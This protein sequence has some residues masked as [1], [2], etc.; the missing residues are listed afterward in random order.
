MPQPVAGAV[1]LGF[2][3]TLIGIG[4]NTWNQQ[5]NFQTREIFIGGFSV[6]LALGL[7][8]LPQGFYD[9]LPRLVGTILKNSVIIVIIL[10][11]IMEQI[12]FRNRT[13]S[14]PEQHSAVL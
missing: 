10:T 3:S 12:I 1:L 9:T 14:K 7:S 13:V 5:K 11:I 6:F 4:A 8:F 2:A